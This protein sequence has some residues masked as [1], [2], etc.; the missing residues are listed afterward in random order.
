MLFTEA[1]GYEIPESQTQI[2]D[3]NVIYTE[4][5][6][7]GCDFGEIFTTDGRIPALDLSIVDDGGA[8]II[9]NVS[10]NVRDEVYQEAPEQFDALV[11]L[12]VD[13]LDEDT[14]A[15]LNRQ[16][17]VE[18]EDAADVANQYFQDQGLI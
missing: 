14:M 16:V 18:G 4:T 6:N 1:T 5:A 9:Y 11:P 8:F 10:L 2:L 17:S 12:L 13:P 3:T 15:E 7:G